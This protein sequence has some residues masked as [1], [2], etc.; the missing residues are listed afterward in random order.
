MIS[1]EKIAGTVCNV[2]AECSGKL[3]ETFVLVKENCSAKEVEEYQK[4]MG[5]IM[6]YMMLGVRDPL[7]RMHPSLV[8][9]ELKG[10]YEDKSNDD[11]AKRE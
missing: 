8:P 7:Y 10:V 9:E 11:D 4:I 1:D 6:G 3:N 5:K 2:V